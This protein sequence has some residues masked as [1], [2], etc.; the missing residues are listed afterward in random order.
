MSG[1]WCRESATLGMGGRGRT[2]GFVGAVDGLA[3]GVRHDR[4]ASFDEV[5]QQEESRIARS[6]ELAGE[7]V[8]GNSKSA[9]ARN[10]EQLEA[11]R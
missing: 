9:R 1:A 2:V 11:E 6:K 4:R 7:E 10:L 8:A 5:V 3:A